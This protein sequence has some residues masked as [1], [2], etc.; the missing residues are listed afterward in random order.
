MPLFPTPPLVSPKFPHVPMRVGGSQSRRC[1]ANYLCNSFQDFQV[2]CMQSTVLQ[3]GLCL[4]AWADRRCCH[5]SPANSAEDTHFYGVSSALRIFGSE[6]Q[7][8]IYLT[9]CLCMGAFCVQV[10]G[11]YRATLCT[12]RYLWY[13]S[14]CLSV[15]HTRGLCPHGSTYDHDFFTIW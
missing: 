13:N 12:A 2:L 9:L 7:I 4:D 15:C 10:I 14:V 8:N 1:W 6:T 5:S 3:E 11:F